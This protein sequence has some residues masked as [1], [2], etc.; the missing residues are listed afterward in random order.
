MERRF[1]TSS[2]PWEAHMGYTQDLDDKE[3]WQIETKSTIRKVKE[4]DFPS[5]GFILFLVICVLLGLLFGSNP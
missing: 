5:R 4:D 3:H 2:P 1:L